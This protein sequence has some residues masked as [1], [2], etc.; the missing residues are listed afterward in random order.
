[1]VHPANQAQRFLRSPICIHSAP[2]SVIII[3][4]RRT[5]ARN[6]LREIFLMAE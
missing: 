3:C 5:G 1:M 2:L 4:G 6:T